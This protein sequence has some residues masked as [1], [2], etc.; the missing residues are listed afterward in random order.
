MSEYLF[1]TD[2]EI[3]TCRDCPMVKKNGCP[4]KEWAERRY[5][6]CPIVEVPPHGRL[7]DADCFLTETKDV[8]LER[9][10]KN[11]GTEIIELGELFA[12]F[13]NNAPTIIEASEEGE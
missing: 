2:R 4:L 7:I 10:I 5:G 9:P 1:K 6:T 3:M 12:E 8:R 13:I 11:N